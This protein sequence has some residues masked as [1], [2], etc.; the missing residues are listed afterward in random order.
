MRKENL[1]ADELPL[2]LGITDLE[3]INLE[4]N[5]PTNFF[6]LI[7]CHV[8]LRANHFFDEVDLIIVYEEQLKARLRF[9]L[10]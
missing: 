5:L 10:E 6:E 9:P 1:L 7:K 3:L 8:D 4:F 2:V